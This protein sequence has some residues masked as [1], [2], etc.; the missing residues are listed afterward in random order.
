MKKPIL[1]SII[2]L[3]LPLKTLMLE[4]TTAC[5]SSWFHLLIT[6]LEKK[7]LTYLLI[8]LYAGSSPIKFRFA[9]S[10]SPDPCILRRTGVHRVSAVRIS[11]PPHT[12]CFMPPAVIVRQPPPVQSFTHR[13]L[14]TTVHTWIDWTLQRFWPA[15][16]GYHSFS[17]WIALCWARVSST[18]CT[19]WFRIIINVRFALGFNPD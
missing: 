4:A 7:I 2:L 6:L 1:V 13:Y 12:G 15:D 16:A 11:E 3:N 8:Y 10:L 18:H 14:L 9:L 19:A 5:W 17:R